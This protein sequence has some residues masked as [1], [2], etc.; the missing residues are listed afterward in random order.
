MKTI[1]GRGAQLNTH[2]RFL[3]HEHTVRDDFLNYCE[4]EGDNVDS[5]KTTYLE[6]FSKTISKCL[7]AS[8]R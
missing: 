7:K 6:I 3:Q 1:K 5:N 4:K 2:N 8:R